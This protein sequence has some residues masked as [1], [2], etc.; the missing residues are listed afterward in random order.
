MKKLYT[1]LIASFIGASGLWAQNVIF[2]DDFE[3]AG[4]PSG[5]EVYDEDN[6]QINNQIASSFQNAWNRLRFSGSSNTFIASASWFTVPGTADDW[7][8]LP[9]INLTENNILTYNA[10]GGGG[11]GDN[12]YEVLIS[13]TNSDLSSFSTTLLSISAEQNAWNQR[14]VDL[15]SYANQQVYIAFRNTSYDGYIL[16]IDDIVISEVTNYDVALEE[17]LVPDNVI[18]S[19][20]V[21]V[22]VAIKN[23]GLL[24]NSCEISWSL[25]NG[26][27]YSQTFTG[28]NVSAG[29]TTH[30]T[31]NIPFVAK[32]GGDFSNLRVWVSNPNSQSDADNANNTLN[33]SVFVGTGAG[34]QRKVLFEEFTTAACVWCPDGHVVMANIL[35]QNSNVIPVSVHSCFGT[36]A[37]TN[38]E[39]SELCSTLGNNSAPTGMVDRIQHEGDARP[40]HSRS[41]WQS[42]VNDRSDVPAAASLVLN[43]TYNTSTRNVAIDVDIAF[44]EY[45]VDGDIRLSL[46]VIE[47]SVSG[48]GTGWD[49]RNALN[50][51]AGHPMYGRGNPIVGYQHRHVLRDILP[52]TWGD[53]SVVPNSPSIDTKYTKSFNFTL[54]N[55]YNSERVSFVAVLSYKGVNSDGYEVINAKEVKLSNDIHEDGIDAALTSVNIPSAVLNGDSLEI[56]AKVR[57]VGADTLQSFDLNWSLDNGTVYTESFNNLGLVFG[58]ELEFSHS[59]KAELVGLNSSKNI[60]VWLTNINGGFDDYAPNNIK[61]KK[62]KISEAI[63]GALTDLLFDYVVGDGDNLIVSGVITNNGVDTL[64]SVDVNWTVNGGT[65]NSETINNLN[66]SHGESIEFDHTTPWLASGLGST[67]QFNVWIEN[68][69]GVTE[70][71]KNNDSL[72]QDVD[73]TAP[74]DLKLEQLGVSDTLIKGETIEIRGEVQNIGAELVNSF[75]ISW[76][77][78]GGTV[79]KETIS[80]ISIPYNA[81][82]NFI[83]K[84]RYTPPASL[85]GGELSVYIEEVNGAASS[86]TSN[87]TINNSFVAIVGIYENPSFLSRLSVYPNPTS[88]FVNLEIDLLG[89]REVEFNLFDITGKLLL[90]EAYGTLSVGNHV[91]RIKFADI[92]NGIYF[93][94]LRMGDD[95]ITRKI[96]VSK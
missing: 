43:G 86:V 90:S 80:N 3:T 82:Y 30:L 73:V 32:N 92:N 6:N 64:N 84:D 42:R 45:V 59:D 24:L 17:I 23:N 38:Q 5:Y 35:S 25:N 4:F 52:S 66:L 72:S 87:D 50:N 22:K 96:I 26:I 56:K 77:I 39:S 14:N 8:I 16:A 65:I 53:A 20:E 75:V 91:K 76:S 40:A 70:A 1:Y 62:V 21:P 57:N 85:E 18:E 12:S 51:Q 58:D 83:H 71:F 7:V 2:S 68:S 67:N 93:M 10:L 15:S 78:N 88:D 89:N 94:T 63:D 9:A 49:Q 69:N 19:N 46:M 36:D 29:D 31:H 95:L 47:D 55:D 79:Y 34:V 81:S 27:V 33:K 13:T 48:T 54:D 37:M 74:S 60:K 11:R 28:L 61:N 41:L 44:V